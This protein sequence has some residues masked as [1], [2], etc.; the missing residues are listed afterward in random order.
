METVLGETTKRRSVVMYLNIAKRHSEVASFRWVSKAD[1]ITLDFTVLLSAFVLSYLLRF[2][3]DIPKNEA[4]HGC[5]Q[6]PF[7]V[8]LQLLVLQRT[9]VYSFVSRYVSMNE[10]RVFSRAALWSFVPLILFRVCLPAQLNVW[11]IP[12]SIIFADT[13]IAFV[14]VLGLRVVRRINYEQNETR[15]IECE[16]ESH[17]KRSILLVG[18]GRAGVLAAREIQR[19]SGSGL[20]I[21]GFVDDNLDLQGSVLSGI[22][23]LG[24][25]GA[26]P[27]LVSEL[28]IDHVVISIAAAS[29][30]DFRRILDICEQIP[31]KVRVIPSMHELLEGNLKVTRIRDVQIEDLLGREP[32]TLIQEDMQR[33]LAGKAIVVTGAGGSI[34]SELVR[35][36]AQHNPATI[37]LVERCEFALF[38]IEREIRQIRPEVKI[39]PLIADVGDEPRMR[40]IFGRYMPHVVIHAAAH[41][42]VP[43]MEINPGEAVRNN[44]LA[45]RFLGEL[46]GEFGVEAFVLISTDKAVRPTS[47]MGATKRISELVIQDLNN[48]FETRYVA[49]RFG[50][51]IGSTGSVI[52]IFRDQVRMG[53]P[54]T[55][56]HPDM[57]R[58]F[59]TIPEAA[60]LVLQAAAIGEGGEIFILDMGSPVRILDVA[61][62]VIS[63]C[64]LKPFDDIDIVF[65]GI[66]P[67]EKLFE[68]LEITEEQM[69]KTR[70]PK[71]FIGKIMSYP[72]EEVRHALRRLDFLSRGG[73]EAEIRRFIA[74]LLPEAQLK[75]QNVGLLSGGKGLAFPRL[76]PVHAA[77]SQHAEFHVSHIELLNKN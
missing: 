6:L 11:K 51:V 25:T 13:F 33:L 71:I 2:D 4:L 66:R 38:N 35:Q 10:V 29:R 21:K 54:V 7:V 57:I 8:L 3:F 34:G 19:K 28:Q 50:N 36:V 49:V 17:S 39:V 5:I 43:M 63:L 16:G 1:Q 22:K 26:L 32:V 62:R 75:I 72:K 73:D 23:V 56:T 67:G 52:P 45:T 60:Q 44:V 47:V 15:Q 68:E 64:G 9:G 77:I 18:A 55:V 70:H 69:T 59:M 76:R 61:K 58:Y 37:L 42:H 40:Q 30:R 46:A 12:F 48:E 74:N 31:V 65:T 27:R 53:G 24:T 20:E 41:K 14:G